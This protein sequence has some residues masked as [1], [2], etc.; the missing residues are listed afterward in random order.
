MSADRPPAAARVRFAIQEEPQLVHLVFIIPVVGGHGT[1][2]AVIRVVRVQR[3]SLLEPPT[4]FY[5]QSLQRAQL[6]HAPGIPRLAIA[7]LTAW[8]GSAASQLRL[9]D[10]M[11]CHVEIHSLFGLDRGRSRGLR[12]RLGLPQLSGHGWADSK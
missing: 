8:L 5:A 9:A 10:E 11:A 4:H 1:V 2:E 7:A 12:E 6:R 3:D